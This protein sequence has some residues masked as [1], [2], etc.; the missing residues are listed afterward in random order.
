MSGGDIK[1]DCCGEFLLSG[2]S[3]VDGGWSKKDQSCCWRRV[4]T[5][6]PSLLGPRGPAFLSRVDPA[7]EALAAGWEGGC[8]LFKRRLLTSWVVRF[9]PSP[10]SMA[11]D[12]QAPLGSIDN[13]KKFLDQDFDS[14]LEKCL[15]AGKPFSDPTFPAEQKSIGMPED[16]NPAKA[17]KWKRPKVRVYK[18]WMKVSS[19]ILDL[20]R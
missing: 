18:N 16:P 12:N 2:K 13:P 19:E 4:I 15:K 7:G 6:A 17:I 10:G 9:T 11:S 14:L 1:P 3:G 5:A 20:D 8:L